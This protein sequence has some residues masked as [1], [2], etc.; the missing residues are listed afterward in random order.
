MENFSAIVNG[1]YSLTTVTLSSL[2][3][4]FAEVVVT[5]LHRPINITMIPEQRQT[6]HLVLNYRHTDSKSEVFQ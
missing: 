3:S 5:P 4:M 6:I 1:F 2:S